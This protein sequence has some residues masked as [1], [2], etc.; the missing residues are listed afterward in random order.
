M[1]YLIEGLAPGGNLRRVESSPNPNRDP[2]LGG[3][4]NKRR[5]AHGPAQQ[6]LYS[7][8]GHDA[9]NLARVA[10]T[11]TI[12]VLCEGGI[13]HYEAENAKP[14]DL[15]AGCDLLLQVMVARAGVVG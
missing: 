7:S 13:G 2:R 14:E 4:K 6:D 12:I 10:P 5:W 8:A 1:G 15:A 11:G 9:C 3:L